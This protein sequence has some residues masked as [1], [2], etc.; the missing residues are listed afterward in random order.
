VKSD[1]K[2]LSRDSKTCFLV[3]ELWIIRI[4][5]GSNKVFLSKMAGGL[6]V[7]YEC[8]VF[9]HNPPPVDSTGSSMG[10]RRQ[11]QVG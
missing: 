9:F 8:T 1:E 7:S 5:T 10:G 2:Y 6:E 3:T 11:H 4:E